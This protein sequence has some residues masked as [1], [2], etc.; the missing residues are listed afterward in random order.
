MQ[1]TS[2]RTVDARRSTTAQAPSIG[3]KLAT[4]AGFLLPAALVYTGLVLFP[5][6]QAV[7]YSLYRWNGLGPLQNF[8]GLAN[9]QRALS[10]RCV[11]ATRSAITCNSSC[12]RW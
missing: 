8:T 1:H 4:V 2:S 7:Y 6:V 12:Y 3:A 5:I 10:R 11:R 9:Y